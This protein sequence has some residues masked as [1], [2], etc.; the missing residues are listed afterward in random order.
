M[1]EVEHE[2]YVRKPKYRQLISLFFYQIPRNHQARTFGNA[3]LY[4]VHKSNQLE[5][6]NIAKYTYY[7]QTVFEQNVLLSI[8]LECKKVLSCFNT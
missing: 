2:I 4:S 1:G 8:Y 6:Y 7:I 3:R 5:T